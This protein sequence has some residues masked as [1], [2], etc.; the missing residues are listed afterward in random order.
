[1]NCFI[2]NQLKICK[3]SF[4]TFFLSWFLNKPWYTPNIPWNL[5]NYKPEAKLELYFVKFSRTETWVDPAEFLRTEFL[6]NFFP[7]FRHILS[8]KF[9]YFDGNGGTLPPRNIAKISLKRVLTSIQNSL[10]HFVNYA[11]DNNHYMFHEI[12]QDLLWNSVGK[13][14]ELRRKFHTAFH[15]IFPSEFDSIGKMSRNSSELWRDFG[16]PSILDSAGIFFCRNNGYLTWL[17]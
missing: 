15:W 7:E 11:E 5:S 4:W 10:F 16:I 14:T 3:E 13:S 2:G 8:R 6:R 17:D 9:H 12:S 1:M